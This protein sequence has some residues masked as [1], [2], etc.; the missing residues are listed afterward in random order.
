MDSYTETVISRVMTRMAVEIL[1][2]ASI[3]GAA[4]EEVPTRWVAAEAGALAG[5]GPTGTLMT[6][7]VTAGLDR[8]LAVSRTGTEEGAIGVALTVGAVVGAHVAPGTRDRTSGA[9]AASTR[10]NRG[11]AET[12]D[13]MA[14][15]NRTGTTIKEEE[16]TTATLSTTQ[17]WSPTERGEEDSHNSVHCG[18]TITK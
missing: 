17:T 13:Q 12:T 2:L 16:M 5:A 11:G 1:V 7:H 18:I 8:A 6:A 10:V 9:E 14:S 4:V 15:L 3:R